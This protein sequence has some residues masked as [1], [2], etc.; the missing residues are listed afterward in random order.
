MK[1]KDTKRGDKMSEALAI[2]NEGIFDGLYFYGVLCG[3]IG[4]AAIAFFV[5]TTA[6]SVIKLFVNGV[7]AI[8]KGC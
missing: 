8:F 5:I 7:R 6:F 2:F 1:L 3:F 4:F